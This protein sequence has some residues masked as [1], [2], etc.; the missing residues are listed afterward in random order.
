MDPAGTARIQLLADRADLVDAVADMRWLEWGRPPEPTDRTWWRSATKGEAGRRRLPLT[1]VASDS[2]GALGA[3]G[4][5]KF[6]IEERHDRSPWLLGMI[7]RPD[8][9]GTGLGR[10]LLTH[11][12][13]W[14]ADQGYRQLWVANEG[15]A[16]P[17]YQRCGWQL[18]E[19][20]E[21]DGRPNVTVLMKRLPHDAG[22]QTTARL[23]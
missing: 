5:G 3:V 21:R 1:W 11:L 4:L 17:F 15:L 8:R 22:R 19:I 18:Q 20:V 10:G 12:E 14:A 9:G 2:S 13:K 7:I 6:D 16:V 23:R